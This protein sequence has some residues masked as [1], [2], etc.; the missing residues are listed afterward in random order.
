MHSGA[1]FVYAVTEAA[2][3]TSL[4][5]L[6]LPHTPSCFLSVSPHSLFLS[7]SQCVPCHPTVIPSIPLCL[8]MNLPLS[9]CAS[10]CSLFPSYSSQSLCL[11]VCLVGKEG[12]HTVAQEKAE[13][14]R[15]RE[16]GV[17][18][19]EDE[20]PGEGGREEEKGTRK[21]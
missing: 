21:R 9:V 12:L 14:Q 3:F 6:C 13:T 19:E 5:S 8:F 20:T 15:K 18:V 7:L 11:F 16:R 2:Y 10:L 17:W 4:L 1:T